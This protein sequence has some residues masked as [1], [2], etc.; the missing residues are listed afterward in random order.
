MCGVEQRSVMGLDHRDGRVVP[1]EVD[2]KRVEEAVGWLDGRWRGDVYVPD[3][4]LP[5]V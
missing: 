2:P 5:L 4:L 3:E 1:L